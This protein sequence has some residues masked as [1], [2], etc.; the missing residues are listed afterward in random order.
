VS[1]A[2]LR[3]TDQQARVLRFAEANDGR[4][5]VGVWCD[6]TERKAIDYLVR[7]GLL[8]PGSGLWGRDARS[9]TTAGREWLAAHDVEGTTQ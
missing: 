3:L 2:T 6:A 1:A 4:I 8:S 9:L 5:H 7:R